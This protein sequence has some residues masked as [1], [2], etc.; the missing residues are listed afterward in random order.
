M[1]A[2]ELLHYSYEKVNK[3][4]MR[5][6]LTAQALR[7]AKP[8]PMPV[9]ELGVA[10]RGGAAARTAKRSK[11]KSSSEAGGVPVRRAGVS[12]GLF[13]GAVVGQAQPLPY[14]ADLTEVVSNYSTFPY[15]AVGK[16][17]FF[18]ANG[19]AYVGSA[20]LVGRK[21]IITAAHCLYDRD[22]DDAFYSNMTFAP[23]YNGAATGQVEVQLDESVIDP[24]YASEA[25]P[26]CLMWDFG[27][28]TLSDDLSQQFG[29]LG[30]DASGVIE[31][32]LV[33]ALG[34][35]AEARPIPRNRNGGADDPETYPFDGSQMWRSVGDYLGVSGD[36]GG[37]ANEM[38][39]GCSGGPWVEGDV[40]VGLNSHRY[41][42]HD[43][44][45]F[46]PMFDHDFLALIEWLD[47]RGAL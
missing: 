19:D 11:K 25:W 43:N 5:M 42:P 26:N 3:Q 8:F 4:A 23:A 12:P 31:A 40:A 27:A 39:G 44:R 22:D 2:V 21:G 37:A 35:P 29:Y 36:V 6:S 1:A 45:M 18:A 38:T 13:A 30:Y 33:E 10:E 32:T 34:Y 16:M 47:E 9:I 20:W 28:A 7:I 46:S 17:F 24:R 15:S 41:V 14:Q